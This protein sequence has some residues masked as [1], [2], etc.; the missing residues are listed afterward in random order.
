MNALAVSGKRP[1]RHV[2][3]NA[4]DGDVAHARVQAGGKLD[5]EVDVALALAAGE[6]LRPLRTELD[7]LA[8]VGRDPV[9]TGLERLAR[10]L[11]VFAVPAVK[12]G[13]VVAYGV[14]AALLDIE[15]HGRDSL[16]NLRI[17]LRRWDVQR[18]LQ[19]RVVVGVLSEDGSR[20]LHISEGKTAPGTIQRGSELYIA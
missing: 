6:R 4:A 11:E 19:A 3:A 20:E 15:Q 16:D 5:V 8:Q 12:L 9:T 10:D 2:R 14:D 18:G 7:R 17:P 13:G 1:A